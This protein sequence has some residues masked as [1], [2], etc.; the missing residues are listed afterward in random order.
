MSAAVGKRLQQARQEQGLS[1][2]QVAADTHIRL[3]YLQAMEAGQFDLIPSRVQARGFLRYYAN[4]LKI[5]V[6]PLF[7][8]LEGDAVLSLM[9]VDEREDLPADE[10]ASD[11]SL[12]KKE[13]NFAL[14][15][16]GETLKT[17]RETLGLSLE[18]VERHTHL[19]IHYLQ[20]LERGDMEALPSTVQGSGMLKN[21]AEFLS[22]DPEPM[23]LNFADELQEQLRKRRRPENRQQRVRKEPQQTPGLARRFFSRDILLGGLLVISLIVFA[24]W[25]GMQISIARSNQEVQPTPPSIADVLLPSAT[26]TAIPT[27]TA[28]IPSPIEEVVE[29]EA[30]AEPANEAGEPEATQEALDSAF[31]ESAVRVQIVIRQRAYMRVNVDGE[32][33]FNGRVVP[34][35][36]Y[37]F[38]GEQSVEILT[39]N[40]EA[41]YVTYND[42]ELGLL[43]TFGEVRDIVLTIDGLQT[44]T[45]TISPTPTRT[46]RTTPTATLTATQ[47][48]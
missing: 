45:P 42:I 7:A 39:G 8:A 17:Q 34:G 23:L 47:N 40:G 33:E 31:A 48:P 20:A 28:T 24:I 9:V 44:P 36:A 5:D 15:S 30:A 22:L 13:N 3:H 14:T 18:D 29:A 11:T 43:G 19:R 21:Y 27:P 35:A 46:L 38:A 37:A 32:E 1:L 41:L 25:A 12:P 10:A 6:E 4:H 16:V 2:E 26:T